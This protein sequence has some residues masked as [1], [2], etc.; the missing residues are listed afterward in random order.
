MAV[1]LLPYSATH[2]NQLP[3]IM[4]SAKQLD[5]I[6]ASES[7]FRQIGEVF[8]KYQVQ[9]ILGVALLHQ[10]FD[11]EERE[12]LVNIGNVAVPWD[13]QK[14]ESVQPSSWRFT[15]DGL[16]PYEFTYKGT[17]IAMDN[18]IREFLSEYKTV[19]E[20][21]DLKNVLGLCTLDGVNSASVTPT[22]EFTSGRANITL[23][24]DVNPSGGGAVDAM[25]QIKQ[26]IRSS[27]AT[28]SRASH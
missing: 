18:R 14:L 19:L 27:Y 28:W 15:K 13:N 22:M 12:V 17:E 20:N 4:E 2:F 3:G 1:E 7:L 5:K 6:G 26:G 16:M 25:W 21:T 23:P 24:F 11:L 9:S 10:H 8:L